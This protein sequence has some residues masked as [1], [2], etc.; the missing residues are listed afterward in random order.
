MRGYF[1]AIFWLGSVRLPKFWKKVMEWASTT[2]QGIGARQQQGSFTILHMVTACSVVSLS[3]S[4]VL[5]LARFLRPSP[6]SRRLEGCSS[7]SAGQGRQDIAFRAF[8]PS[9]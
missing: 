5:H 7:H 9:S 2:G 6:E 1:R 4:W 3:L 8:R